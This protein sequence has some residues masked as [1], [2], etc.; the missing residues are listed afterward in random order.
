MMSCKNITRAATLEI[1]KGIYSV[2]GEMVDS[3]TS[4]TEEAKLSTVEPI[5]Y[6]VE[7]NLWIP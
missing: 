7:R 5:L 2:I 4:V 6:P 3:T 1:V